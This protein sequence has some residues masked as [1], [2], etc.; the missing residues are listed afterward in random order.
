SLAR[1]WHSS[2]WRRSVTSSAASARS[3]GSP[4]STELPRD[5]LAE[6]L[7]TLPQPVLLGGGA[8]AR[9]RAVAVRE[10]PEAPD[11]RPGGPGRAQRRAEEFAQVLGGL[12][13][14]AA[15]GG[16]RLVL[17]LGALGVLQRHVEEHPLHHVE[18]GVGG[19]LHAREGEGE[20]LVVEGE[21]ARAAAVHV[22]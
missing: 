2:S 17:H 7:P 5:L 12:S 10:A 8:G 19:R 4:A 16:E 15:V 13:E 21:G 14:Q 3:S 6:T 11:D 18:R 22:A 20:C 9:Q 1:R